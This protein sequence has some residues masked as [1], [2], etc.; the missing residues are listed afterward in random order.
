MIS[1]SLPA[2]ASEASRKNGDGHHVSGQ[3]HKSS[4]RFQ[5][6]DGNQPTAEGQPGVAPHD[7][8]IE[9]VALAFCAK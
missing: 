1:R 9:E 7:G 5:Q 2:G 4:T 6:L 3:I 8:G